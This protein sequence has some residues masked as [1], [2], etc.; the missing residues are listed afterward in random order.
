MFLEFFGTFIV[1][2]GIF[3]WTFFG[4]PDPT[5]ELQINEPVYRLNLN[6]VSM[7]AEE[8]ICDTDGL[9]TVLQGT[10]HSL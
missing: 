10:A 2:F 6:S 4:I 8:G 9:T 3:G 1:F 7:N 5:F